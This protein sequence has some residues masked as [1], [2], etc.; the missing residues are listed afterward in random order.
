MELR[1]YNFFDVFHNISISL[2]TLLLGEKETQ[3]PQLE[4]MEAKQKETPSAP[5]KT[6]TDGEKTDKENPI[7]GSV[8]IKI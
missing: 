8:I 6:T 1:L 5:P 4:T 2:F 3:E 7:Q